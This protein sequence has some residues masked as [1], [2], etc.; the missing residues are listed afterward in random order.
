MTRSPRNFA[1][2]LLA[3]MICGCM[4]PGPHEGDYCSTS[5]PD[6]CAGDRSFTCTQ[7][8][9]IDFWSTGILCRAG[10]TCASYRDREKQLLGCRATDLSCQSAGQQFCAG[11]RVIK[12]SIDRQP[13]VVDDCADSLA[14]LPRTC[15]SSTTGGAACSLLPEPCGSD[16]FICVENAKPYQF[17]DARPSQSQGI[18]TCKDGIAGKFRYFWPFFSETC[19]IRPCEKHGEYACFSSPGLPDVIGY[20]VDGLWVRSGMTCSSLTPRCRPEATATLQPRCVAA[21]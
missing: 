11:T 10:S 3:G 2:L 20:C 12:C 6:F 21:D 14:P 18:V 9:F 19:A 13:L 7:S 16:G 17:G 4:D 1:C 15:L 5:E 8:D